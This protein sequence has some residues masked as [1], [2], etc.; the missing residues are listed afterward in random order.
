M[1]DLFND[2]LNLAAA[3]VR[4]RFI[5]YVERDDL[6]NEGWIWRLE[7]ERRFGQYRNDDN[8]KRGR[9]RLLR[10]LTM[11]ME[12]Y[13]RK[14]KAAKLGYSADD[15][16]FYSQA[17]VGLILPSI[18]HEDFDQP[19]QESDGIRGTTDPAEMGTWMAHRTDVAKAWESAPLSDTEREAIALCYGMGMSQREAAEVAGCHHTTIEERCRTGMKK[20]LA[21]LGG[22]KPQG[23]PFTCECHEGKLRL[24]PN[25]HSNDSG[26]NQVTR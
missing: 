19:Q 4:R 10:D 21:A 25:M 23:C 26:M 16:A 8:E 24:R 13:A 20:M 6:V 1:S 11:R 17:L 2:S 7:H 3:D 15:E 22:E 12:Q 5:G 18:L 9:Y 14:E